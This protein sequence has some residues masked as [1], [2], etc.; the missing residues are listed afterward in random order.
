VNQLTIDLSAPS[1]PTLR[2]SSA[3]GGEISYETLIPSDTLLIG[4]E[5]DKAGLVLN[6]HEV[7]NWL[8]SILW[9]T[10]RAS[11]PGSTS[12]LPRVGGT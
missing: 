8:C 10:S 7:P 4:A 12:A 6:C 1:S 2:A 11:P 9:G 5:N 3:A